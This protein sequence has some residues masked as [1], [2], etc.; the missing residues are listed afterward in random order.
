M[1]SI[2]KV[3]LGKQTWRGLNWENSY[4]SGLVD[5]GLVAGSTT[6]AGSPA[7][8]A[9]A[10]GREGLQPAWGGDSCD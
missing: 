5:L 7:Q 4:G 10:L 3:H 2:K 1:A 6:E 9:Q 8:M